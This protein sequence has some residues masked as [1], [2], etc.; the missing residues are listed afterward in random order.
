ME[1]EFDTLESKLKLF[2]TLC[3]RLREENHQ[4]RQELA[5][6]QQGNK[7]LEG[8]IGDAAKRLEDI[9]QQIP[10]DAV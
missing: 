6:A 4:L 9:L 2:V 5:T 7:Q 10:E 8:R 3:Q 1:A